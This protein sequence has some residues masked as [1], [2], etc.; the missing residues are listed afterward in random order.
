MAQKG[1]R[2][3]KA[4]ANYEPGRKPSGRKFHGGARPGAAEPGRG[5]RADAGGTKRDR[6]DTQRSAPG[7]RRDQNREQRSTRGERQGRDQRTERA[8]RPERH[9]RAGRDSRVDGSTRDANAPRGARTA[10]R[11]KLGPDTPLARLEATI[12]TAADA[13]GKTFGDLGLGGNIVRVLGELGAEQPFPIQVATIPDTIAGRDILGRA[14]TGSG[15]TIAFGA[16]LVER[17][18]KLK[19]EGAFGAKPGGKAAKTPRG[20]RVQHR[21][22]RNPRALILAPTRELALQID[23]TIQPIARSVGFYTAQMVGGIPIDP[24]IHALERGVD[25]VIG[26]PGRVQDLVNR[27]KLDLR[28]VLV[29]VLDEADHMCDLGFLEPVQQVLR[30]TE[31]GGQR[32]LFSATLDSGVSELVREFLNDPAV[33]EAEAEADGKIRHRVHVVQRDHK[34]QALIRL[35]KTPGR[36]LIFCRTRAYAEQVADMLA[37]AGL[38]VAAL[39]GDLS[40]TRRERNLAQF[41]SGKKPVLVA[42]DVAARGIH[43][44]DVDLVLQADPPNDFKTYLHR[45]GRTGRAGRDGLVVTVIPHARQER[46]R[47]MLEHAGVTPETFAEWIPKGAAPNKKPRGR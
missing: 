10:H 36:V 32:L 22:T 15:K 34:D 29:T 41:A 24:Q 45:A 23:R 40:Q 1:R 43:V 39:H 11:E 37:D 46:T 28:E 3:F 33:H 26:T 16:A 6:E 8:G 31:R 2:G 14:R 19:A 44:D 30:E 35:A 13:A 21:P 18:L 42:T 27:R 12:T 7:D 17:M 9:D 4:P 47:E 5:G 25:I 20:V 38:N